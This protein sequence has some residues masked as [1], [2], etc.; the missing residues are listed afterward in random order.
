M[1]DFIPGFELSRR[2][3]QEVVRQILEEQF[4]TI[5][6][7]A[8]FLGHGSEVMGFDTERSVDHHWGPQFQLFLTENAY[9]QY[10]SEIRSVLSENLPRKEPL[11]VIQTKKRAS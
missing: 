7:S 4:P 5:Q 1:V 8:A 6:Y 9:Q 2:F 3:Y 11:A 10:G